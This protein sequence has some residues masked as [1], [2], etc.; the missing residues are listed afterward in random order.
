MIEG[1]K[2]LNS[3]EINEYSWWFTV[4]V[5]SCIIFAVM[6]FI[7]ILSY[8][9]FGFL[10]SAPM[11]VITLGAIFISITCTDSVKK[12]TG[13]YRYECYMEDYV[14]INVISE[15]YDIIEQRGDIWILEDKKVEE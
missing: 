15:K 1:V 2:V 5:L 13:R 7:S 10:I 3:A 11:L 12:P 4:L 6:I 9:D 8:S 14:S